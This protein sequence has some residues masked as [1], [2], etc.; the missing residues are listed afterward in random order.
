[1]DDDLMQHAVDLTRTWVQVN[2]AEPEEVPKLIR[3]IYEEL[4]SL[5]G[6]EAPAATVSRPEQTVFDD[7]IVC[8]ED[9]AKVTLLKRYIKSRFGMTPEEYIQKWNLPPDYPFVAPNYSKKRSSI[10]REQRLGH[11]LKAS[12]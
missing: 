12:A 1:M 11:R 8:L 3:M 6:M 10:A 5:E 2:V 9:G 4:K 7:Y